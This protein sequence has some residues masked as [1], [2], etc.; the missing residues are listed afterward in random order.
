MSTAAAKAGVATAAAA[1]VAVATVAV[2]MAAVATIP[3][4][5]TF[6]VQPIRPH[7]LGP[8]PGRQAGFRPTLLSMHPCSPIMR[9]AS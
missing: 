2:A 7:P 6:T 5:L 9:T 4:A 1:E 8:R 3:A